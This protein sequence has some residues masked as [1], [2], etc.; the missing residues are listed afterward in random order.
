[1][2]EW[3][4]KEGAIFEFPQNNDWAKKCGWTAILLTT[5]IYS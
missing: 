5:D 3:N 4:T 2:R 1:M